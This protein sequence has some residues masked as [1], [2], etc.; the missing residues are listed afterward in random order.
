M[1]D[2]CV[3]RAVSKGRLVMGEHLLENYAE[4]VAMILFGIGFTADRGRWGAKRGGIYQSGSQ[5]PCADGNCRICISYGAYA[6][7]NNPALPQIPY[8]GFG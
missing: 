1:Y 3:L 5:R 7:F 6:F 2:V 8:A 4:V